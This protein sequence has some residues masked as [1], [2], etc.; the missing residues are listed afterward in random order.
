MKA[1]DDTRFKAAEPG[2]TATYRGP[3]TSSARPDCIGGFGTRLA[4]SHD[5]IDRRGPDFAPIDL[6]LLRGIVPQPERPVSDERDL[7]TA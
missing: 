4:E 7:S 6:H 5:A 3:I 2:Y 1:L